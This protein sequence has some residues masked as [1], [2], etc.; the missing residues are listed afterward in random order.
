MVSTGSCGW[1]CI[2]RTERQ[3][4]LPGNVLPLQYVGVLSYFTSSFGLFFLLL[5]SP[6][7]MILL[8]DSTFLLIILADCLL[9]ETFQL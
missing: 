4:D 9:S 2:L 8:A 5:I 7:H 6:R 3:K 1:G